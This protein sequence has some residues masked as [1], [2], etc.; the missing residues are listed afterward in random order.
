MELLGVWATLCSFFFLCLQYIEKQKESIENFR[1]NKMK[2]LIN[3]IG[4]NSD[5]EETKDSLYDWLSTSYEKYR[6][7]AGTP[8]IYLYF[9]A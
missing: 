7:E 9:R 4:I 8:F 6:G 5:V 3:E 1:L 2:D